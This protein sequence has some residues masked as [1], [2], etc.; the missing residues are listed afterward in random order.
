[1]KRRNGAAEGFRM[2][3]AVGVA[4][5]EGFGVAD[6]DKREAVKCREP[7][8]GRRTS[9]RKPVCKRHLTSLPYP[10]MIQQELAKRGLLAG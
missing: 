2:L 5:H 3:E 7:G 1:M 6:W 8:C 9:L 4:E 10:A